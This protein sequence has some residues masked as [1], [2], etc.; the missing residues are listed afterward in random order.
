MSFDLRGYQHDILDRA[1]EKMRQGARSILITSPTGSGKTVLSAHM[2][3]TSAQKNKRS[4]F[5]MHRRELIK[6][7]TNTF[8]DVGV[9]HGVIAAK[10]PRDPDPMVQLSAIGTLANRIHKIN[11]PDLIIWDECHHIAAGSWSK[12]YYAYPKA[13]HIG[14]TATPERLD[15]KGLGEFFQTIVPGPEVSWLIENNYLCKYKIFAPDTVNTEGLKKSGYDFNKA[16][17]SALMDKPSITGDIVKTYLK[18]A[19]LKSAI[20][21]AP[22]VEM[23]E[24]LV[25]LANANG[26]P[27]MH[28]DGETESDVRDRAIEDFKSGRLRW[29]SNVDLFGE[30][31]DVPGIEV[32]IDAAPTMSLGRYLQRFGRLLRT[33]VG[34]LEGIYLDHAGNVNR[35]GLP[36]DFR[37]W[38]LDGR[39]SRKKESDNG[40][41]IRTCNVCLAALRIHLRECNFC[42][43]SFPIDSRVIEQVDGELKEI[44]PAL[45]RRQRA[46]EQGSAQTVEQLIAV[47]VSRGMKKP[48]MWAKH[49]FN[50][51]QA[52]KLLRGY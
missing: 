7:S 26:I 23:S 14:L 41:K 11:R 40:P 27:A 16:A 4:M 39:T 44:D 47:G 38:T 31:F 45:M 9:R 42:G 21:F 19:M 6:Q 2:L 43:F 20:V 51:R 35:H 13:F 24:H 5:L 34:K 52:K 18:H 48:E 49:V 33:K 22:S 32:V 46:A 3:N 17:V 50:A 12:I 1:R 15:G 37:E 36:D 29:L 8:S 28:V 10:F 30:G 25:A